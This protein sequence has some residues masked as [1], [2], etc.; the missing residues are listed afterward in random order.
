M[1]S[2]IGSVISRVLAAIGGGIAVEG[3][4]D[5]A[6]VQAAIGAATV[7]GTIAWNVFKKWGTVKA[8]TK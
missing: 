7:L 4:L 1:G 3:Y 2:V 5:D 8:E 6:T